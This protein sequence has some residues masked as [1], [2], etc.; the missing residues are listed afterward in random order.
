[1]KIFFA[2]QLEIL[3]KFAEEV[4]CIDG[5]HGLNAHDFELTTLLILDDMREGLETALMKRQ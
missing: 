3:E 1:M 5:T 4:I 2:G